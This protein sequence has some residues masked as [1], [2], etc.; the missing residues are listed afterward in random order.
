M[1]SRALHGHQSDVGE[2]KCLAWTLSTIPTVAPIPQTENA[3][4]VVIQEGTSTT[5]EKQAEAAQ[6]A[7]EPAGPVSQIESA[8]EAVVGGSRKHERRRISRSR[9]SNLIRKK[10]PTTLFGG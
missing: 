9:A 4:E 10:E 8:P 5:D 7:E 3:P 1:Q 6:Q 2:P